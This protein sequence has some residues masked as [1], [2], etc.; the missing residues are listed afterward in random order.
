M[1]VG[2]CRF[3]GSGGASGVVLVW[4]YGL[5]GFPEGRQPGSFAALARFLGF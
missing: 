5:G 2:S 1:K 4:V 3:L